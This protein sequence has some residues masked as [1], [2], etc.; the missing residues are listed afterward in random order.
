[1]EDRNEGGFPGKRMK[2]VQ[3]Y[4]RF[5]FL[6]SN[7]QAREAAKV[8]A[9]FDIPWPSIKYISIDMSHS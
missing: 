5:I 3:L 1:M 8:A 2:E 7:V 6:L 9:G 4:G